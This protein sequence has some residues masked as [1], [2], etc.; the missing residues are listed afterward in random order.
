M[1]ISDKLQISSFVNPLHLVK[2][3]GA[4]AS[5]IGDFDIGARYTWANV[6][7]PF[8]LAALAVE[9]GFP[10]GDAIKG[11]GWRRLQPF[12]GLPALSRVR[13]GR[14]CLVQIANSNYSDLSFQQL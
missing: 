2:S 9:A 10:T 7:S 11:M 13:I 4:L 14:I 6:G 3:N 1:G 12:S 5:G 8:M